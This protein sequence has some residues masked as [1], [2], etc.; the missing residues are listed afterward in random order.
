MPPAQTPR[1]NICVPLS[2]R[3]FIRLV[4]PGH[5]FQGDFGVGGST[6][7]PPRSGS[8]RGFAVAG[9]VVDDLFGVAR[10]GDLLN[11]RLLILGAE[12]GEPRSRHLQADRRRAAR[13]R[14]RC[15]EVDPVV[16]GHEL[17]HRLQVGRLR[18]IRASK[19]VLPAKLSDLPQLIASIQSSTASIDGVLMVSPSK[20]AAM[21]LP[22]LVMRKILGNGQAGL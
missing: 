3:R 20:M 17:R 2:I 9:D 1:L 22:A 7:G 21:S 11:E 18:A 10:T 16:F 6:V 19:P 15:E 5:P 14:V 4:C 12:R 8:P 13:G